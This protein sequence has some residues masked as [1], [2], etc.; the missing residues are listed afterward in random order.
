MKN[1]TAYSPRDPLIALGREF[2]QAWQRLD[3]IRAH[4]GR[5]LP[6]WPKW[7]YF[8]MNY[9]INCFW[10]KSSGPPDT[11]LG[12]QMSRFA[13]L[14]TWRATQ[15]IYRFD[16]D[17]YDAVVETPLA[18][19]LPSDV[20]FRLPE[21]CVYVETKGMRL[22]DD[23]VLGAFA[24]LDFR[25]QN[26]GATL[27]LSFNVSSSGFMNA[28][29]E[30]GPWPLLEGMK[31]VATDDAKRYANAG[32]II[33][34]PDAIGLAPIAGQ[35]VSLLLYLCSVNGEI[36]DGS[37][38]P[39]NPQPTRTKNGLRI[40]PPDQPRIWNVG[41]R[42][43]TALRRAR[44]ESNPSQ[45]GGHASP[46]PHFRRAHWQ[47]YWTGRRDN[48]TERRTILKWIHPVLVNAESADELVSVI[49]RVD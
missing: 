16:E 9:F 38:R 19:D 12:L 22:G 13:I 11:D 24:C 15:G 30:L 44:S 34:P 7:C 41:I 27:V 20:L 25:P 36:G 6:D 26:Q 42:V 49:K 35:V 43:G 10:D 5:G 37:R 46:R 33:S 4:R 31:R 48:L 14:G 8:P 17:V 40:F 3:A 23:K 18:G 2:P 45:E 28:G 47:H 29:I 21:W 1:V 39:R 32:A